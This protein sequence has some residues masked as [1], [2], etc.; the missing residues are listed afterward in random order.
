MPHEAIF[1]VTCRAKQLR[2]ELLEPLQRVTPHAMA[3]IVVTQVAD[4][5][6]KSKIQF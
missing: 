5:V 1:R 2:D 6:A 3:K 4:I